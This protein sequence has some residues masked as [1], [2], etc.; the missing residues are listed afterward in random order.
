[1]KKQSNISKLMEFEWGHYGDK[2]SGTFPY[3]N[4]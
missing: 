4:N 2:L 3:S 1:M